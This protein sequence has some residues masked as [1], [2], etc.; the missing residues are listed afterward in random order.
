[1]STGQVKIK[2]VYDS[3]APDDGQRV[4]VDRLWPRGLKRED[5]RLDDWLRDVAPSD[6]LRHWFG[7]DP[8]RWDEF[9]AR[10]RRELEDE[11]RQAALEKLRDLAR[12]GPLT[13]L[14]AAKDTEHCNAQVLREL[15]QTEQAGG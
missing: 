1:M 8:A 9:R 6:D 12:R 3:P 13:L 15:L 11:R 5:A 2:R 7:H 4:L 14:F 10:Y